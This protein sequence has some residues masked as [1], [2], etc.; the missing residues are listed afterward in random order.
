MKRLFLLLSA[1]AAGLCLLPAAPSQAQ[2]TIPNPGFDTWTSRF[3]YEA[4]TN[5]LTSDD[6]WR[7]MGPNAAQGTVVKTTTA[8]TGP[9]AAELQTK[10][11]PTGFS[12][13][14]VGS[15]FLGNSFSPNLFSGQG[16]PSALPFSGR[17]TALQFYYQLMGPQAVADEPFAGVV[18]TRRVNG[19]TTI[20]GAGGYDF[21]ALAPTYTQASMPI[22]YFSALTPDSISVQFRSGDARTTTAGTILRIDDITLVGVAT[23]TRAAQGVDLTFWPNPSPDGR[24]TL[25]ATEPTV[26]AAPLTVLDALGRVVRQEAAPAASLTA[27]TLDLSSLPTGIYTVQLFSAQGLVTRRLT[28]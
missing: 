18:L 6:F 3:G 2:T 27:R 25:A 4:P 5:W 14:T 20:V 8:R 26:L 7:T 19:S 21:R 22:Y 9:Y 10:D 13:T 23:S 16:P 11:R 1:L 28:R 12:G 17:P 24:F 15:L